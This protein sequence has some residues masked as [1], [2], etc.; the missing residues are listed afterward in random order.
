VAQICI[1]RWDGGCK[2][3]LCSRKIT[4]SSMTSYSGKHEEE[5]HFMLKYQDSV[6]L[7]HMYI[8]TLQKGVCI[9]FRGTDYS[10][11]YNLCDTKHK[12]DATL[13]IIVLPPSGSPIQ[14]S[15]PEDTSTSSGLNW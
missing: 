4:H 8:G 5:S 12:Q 10:R 2:K 15:K 14:A 6:C 9:L 7:L 13:Y 3:H 1:I 11:K